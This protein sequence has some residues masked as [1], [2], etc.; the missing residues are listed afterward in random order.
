MPVKQ[1]LWG[2]GLCGVLALAHIPAAALAQR[3]AKEAR[4]PLDA[5]FPPTVAQCGAAYGNALASKVRPAMATDLSR[6]ADAIAA[7]LSQKPLRR[8][9]AASALLPR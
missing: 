6:A 2:V 8:T 1:T 7:P 4:P 3:K 9:Q 5:S